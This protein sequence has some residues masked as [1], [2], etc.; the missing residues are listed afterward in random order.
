VSS[1]FFSSFYFQKCLKLTVY[2]VVDPY[3]C[4]EVLDR[5]IRKKV[6]PYRQKDFISLF[7]E[8]FLFY[9]ILSDRLFIFSYRH[10]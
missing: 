5:T 3:S 6:K 7:N 4:R 1:M 8:D 9:C 10:P 2:P